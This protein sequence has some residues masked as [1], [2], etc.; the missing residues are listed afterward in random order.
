MPSTSSSEDKQYFRLPRLPWLVVVPPGMALLAAA[1]LKPDVIPFDYLG[2]LKGLLQSAITDHP[3]RVQR[4]AAIVFL[5]HGLE[6]IYA[7]Y[8]AR[9][10]KLSGCVALAW[11][12]QTFIYGLFSLIPLRR[13]YKKKRS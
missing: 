12:A 4:I 3:A 11:G 6:A 10:N 2:P 13:H 8:F 5:I 9:K 7:T 1:A